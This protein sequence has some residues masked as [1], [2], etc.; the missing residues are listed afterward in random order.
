M[1]ALPL[2]VAFLQEGT[3]DGS[4][5]SVVAI[6]I[7][8]IIGLIFFAIYIYSIVWVYRDANQRGKSGI[9]VALLVALISWPIGLVVWLL[10]RDKV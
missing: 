2:L 4:G 6:I 8:L 7:G 10:V 9:L 5:T 3:S 1:S